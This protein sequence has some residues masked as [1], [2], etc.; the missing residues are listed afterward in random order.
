M[1]FMRSDCNACGVARKQ[2]QTLWSLS[3]FPQKLITVAQ[4]EARAEPRQVSYGN[5]TAQT[6]RPCNPY[7]V[8]CLLW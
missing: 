5:Q 7:P 6:L 4:D 8:T 3:D 1:F 2:S